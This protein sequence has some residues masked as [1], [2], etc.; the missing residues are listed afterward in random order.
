MMYA[1]QGDAYAQACLGIC[2]YRGTGV[3]QNY[4]EAVNWCRKA[5]ERG[6]ADAQAVL[7]NCYYHGTGVEQNY[8]EAVNWYRK[9]AEQGHAGAQGYLEARKAI[10]SFV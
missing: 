6:D 7:G 5:A 8:G 1:E 10:G 3:E 2:Y 4:G 9:A